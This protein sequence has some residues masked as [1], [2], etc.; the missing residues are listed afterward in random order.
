MAGI[1][2]GLWYIVGSPSGSQSN[3]FD[4]YNMTVINSSAV[5]G[6]V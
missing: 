6:I 5:K 2:G 4:F 1:G 3:G